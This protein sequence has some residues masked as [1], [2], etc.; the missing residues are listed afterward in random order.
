MSRSKARVTAETYNRDW[1]FPLKVRYRFQKDAEP[2]IAKTRS[3]AWETPLGP[4]VL[5]EGVT[6]GV[7][8]ACVEPAEDLDA[9]P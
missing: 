2:R 7:P 5:L 9:E 6:G 4:V 8:L 3:T 1:P